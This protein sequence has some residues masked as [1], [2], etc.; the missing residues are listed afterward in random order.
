[1]LQQ[2]WEVPARFR[3]AP[4]PMPKS[5]MRSD[6]AS[7]VNPDNS[8]LVS[9]KTDGVRM[10][11]LFSWFSDD[12]CYAAFI[13]R[14]MHVTRIAVDTTVDELYN[15]T[16]LDGE[17]CEDGTYVVFD[18]IAV[19]GFDMKQT[20]F[21]KRLDRLQS[22]ISHFTISEPA[23]PVLMKE[24]VP[25]ATSNVADLVNNQVVRSDGLIFYPSDEVL[26]PGTQQRMFKWKPSAQHTID[27]YV[28]WDSVNNC[29]KLWLGPTRNV[30]ASAVK[31][32]PIETAFDCECDNRVVECSLS[33]VKPGKTAAT[34]TWSATPVCARPDKTHGNSKMVAS[35]TLKNIMENIQ[36]TEFAAPREN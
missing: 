32:T 2:L 5:L 10:F 13:D 33:V 21:R 28:T 31:I 26:Y 6:I 18:I 8:Y 27:F 22:C 12:D 24:W 15:G 16:L 35:A 23:H 1:M 4:M 30:A 9:A 34:T 19:H 36:L 11:L 3:N 14:A 7:V 25:V 20:A 17:L 29:P